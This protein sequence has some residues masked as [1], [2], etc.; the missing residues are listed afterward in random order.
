MTKATKKY[1]NSIAELAAAAVAAEQPSNPAPPPVTDGPQAATSTAW[2]SRSVHPL[3]VLETDYI[4]VVQEAVAKSGNDTNKAREA[5]FNAMSQYFALSSAEPIPLLPETKPL[6]DMRCAGLKAQ[7]RSVREL[8]ATDEN[9]IYDLLVEAIENAL[10]ILT[11]MTTAQTVQYADDGVK[12]A[13]RYIGLFPD[14]AAQALA[15]WKQKNPDV[16]AKWPQM[17]DDIDQNLVQ[18]ILGGATAVASPRSLYNIETFYLFRLMHRFLGGSSARPMDLD[19]KAIA[20]GAATKTMH[21]QGAEWLAAWHEGQIE[22]LASELKVLGARLEQ[23]HN[24]NEMPICFYLKGG[25]AMNVCLGTPKEGANDWDTGVLIDPNLPPHIWYEVFSAVND[26]VLHFLDQSRFAYTELLNE[27]KARLVTVDMVPTEAADTDEDPPEYTRVGLLVEHL[28][29]VMAGSTGLRLGANNR[30]FKLSGVNGELIDIGISTRNSVE[31]AEHW[32]HM[33]IIEKPGTTGKMIPVPFLPYFVDDFTTMIRE[34]IATKTVGPKLKKRF[35]RLN[36]VLESDDAGLVQTINDRGAFI[37][38]LLP[39]SY[40]ALAID[41]STPNGRLAVW[42][43]A[44]LALSVP[45]YSERPDWAEAFD[46]YTSGHVAELFSG[47]AIHSF[48]S[49]LKKAFDNEP[50]EEEAVK[51]LLIV[52]TGVSL[53]A[54]LVIADAQTLV[55][56]IGGDT[57]KGALWQPVHTYLDAIFKLPTQSIHGAFALSGGLASQ[58]QAEHAGVDTIVMQNKN[59]CGIVEVV[60]VGAV[61]QQIDHLLGLLA[62]ALKPIKGTG[63]RVV[64]D[65]S[66]QTITVYTD[67]PIK[68]AAIKVAHP[69]ILQVRVATEVESH[70]S[71]DFIGGMPVVRT[72]NL[73]NL[74]TAR[75]SNSADFDIRTAEKGFAEILLK[76]VLGRQIS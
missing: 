46:T 2:A 49:E 1:F 17:V 39:K 72:R 54:H 33:K 43:L 76:D 15:D 60:L 42:L 63:C 31:L 64:Y 7:I 13:A 73:V 51:R 24:L 57:H 29:D 22:R 69:A 41:E 55:A 14:D 27:N 10:E 23:D 52:E 11:R 44:E 56:E 48:W 9:A 50:L 12:K 47:K 20:S 34:A 16:K 68:G 35:V 74:Y 53:L 6:I 26:L 36:R 3:Q 21:I 75:A 37:M 25:R 28:E 30:P 4:N 66:A 62:S 8:L 40:K 38:R 58:V 71:L 61:Q 32:A 70:G 59:T 5:E 67:K 45:A 19:E 18:P 65:K